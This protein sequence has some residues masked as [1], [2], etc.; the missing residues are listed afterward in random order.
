M[1]TLLLLL[2]FSQVAFPQNENP[3]PEDSVFNLYLEFVHSK[4]QVAKEENNIR[5]LNG[6]KFALSRE[7]SFDFPFDSLLKYKV[8]LVS[9]DKQIRL[10]TWNLESENG[11]HSFYGFVQS[12][13]KKSKM[14]SLY[15]LYDKSEVIRDP[16]NA[17]LESAKWYGAYYYQI[18]EKKS[19]KKR[20][21]ILLGWDGNNR[22]TNKKIIDVLFFNEKGVPK[23]GKEI[24][25]VENGRT[26]KRIIFEYQAGIFMTLR[27]EEEKDRIVFDHLSPS[28]PHLEGQYQFY[29]PDFTYDA[30]QFK[31]KKWRYQKNVDTRNP[32]DR[33][34]KYFSP[35]K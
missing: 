15:Q 8:L 13:N 31:D 14:P 28:H 25:V 4:N 18:I 24:F 12:H 23:F 26:K 3:S 34:D 21:Y 1:K 7:N 27:Y 35:P 5:F 9:S 22:I 29:G 33:T 16:E 30:F 6:L 10:F 20:Y 17:V 32:K 11:T 19:K 2:L